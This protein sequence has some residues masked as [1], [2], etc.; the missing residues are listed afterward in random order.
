MA[1]SS[2]NRYHVGMFWE[3]ALLEVGVEVHATAPDVV[4]LQT[5]D[6]VLRVRVERWARPLH[7]VEVT[8][9]VGR[10][11]HAEESVLVVAD[12][13][14]P[15][16]KA[17]L[18]RHQVS[19]VTGHSVFVALPPPSA[20]VRR[21]LRADPQRASQGGPG[22]RL[23][24]RGR[25]AYQ[26]LRRVIQGG[27]RQPQRRIARDAHVSQPRVSQVLAALDDLGLVDRDRGCL[28]AV[29]AV[30]DAWLRDYPGPGGVTTRWFSG[31]P[32]AVV[33]PDVL[34]HLAVLDI[35]V[36]VSGS[37]AADHLSPY[38]LPR[39]ARLYVDRHADLSAVGLVRT[40]DVATAD[41]WVTVAD[42]PTIAPAPHDPVIPL[43]FENTTGVL[44]D[45]LQVLWDTAGEAD[46]DAGQAADALRR[47]L[48]ETSV[49][50]WHA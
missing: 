4:E 49:E 12:H 42:D 28:V 43:P 27:L 38:A 26:V 48:L 25:S 17:L 41:V 7:P 23:P 33:V 6:G 39:H 14:S 31:Q 36:H 32:M 15:R 21:A 13:V 46:V 22:L 40:P 2:A 30:L 35:D 44:A 24:W 11:G 29:P 10:W 3:D 50:R 34:R 5:P 19:Y 16:V 37:F 18:E 8:E 9:R 45:P 47:W 1:T 20:P